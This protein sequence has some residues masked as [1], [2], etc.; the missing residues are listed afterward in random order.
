MTLVPTNSIVINGETYPLY[1]ASLVIA[2]NYLNGNLNA[3]TVMSLIPTRID[4][5]GN[6]IEADEQ[7]ISLSLASTKDVSGPEQEVMAKIH[8]AIQTYIFQKGL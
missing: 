3:S 6:T 5:S 4:G 1:S 2:A 7:A 8:D